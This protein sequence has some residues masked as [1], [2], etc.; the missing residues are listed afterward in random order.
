MKTWGGSLP[1]KK[2][3]PDGHIVRSSFAE[4]KAGGKLTH[5]CKVEF[6]ELNLVA[7]DLSGGPGP[8]WPADVSPV[9]GVILCYD[10]TRSETLIGLSEALARLC[11]GMP[12]VLLACKSDPDKTLEVEAHVGDQI[13]HPY[14]VGLIEVTT[15]TSQGKGKMRTGLR[16]LLYKLEEMNRRRESPEGAN[17]PWQKGH[18]V[19]Q[20]KG[21]ASDDQHSSS[22]SLG[23]MMEG[24]TATSTEGSLESEPTRAGGVLNPAEGVNGA[25]VA[26]AAAVA[27][28]PSAALAS[29]ASL[30][31]DGSKPEPDIYVTLQELFNRLFTAIVSTEN[32]QFVNTFFL[33]YRRFCQPRELMTE[34]LERFIE[35]EQYAVSRDIRLWAL[36]KLAGALKDWATKYPGDLVDAETQALF[37]KT[38]GCMLKYTFLAHVTV[39]LVSIE[40]GLDKVVDLDQSWSC[41]PNLNEANI[42]TPETAAALELVVE[43]DG[44]LFEDEVAPF[45]PTDSTTALKEKSGS[46]FSRSTASL[47][48]DLDPIP[49][50]AGDS[51][52]EQSRSVYSNDESGHRKWSSAINALMHMEPHH[53]ALELTLMQW[54][55]FAAIRPRD[56][57]RHDFGKERDDPVGRSIDFFNHLSR[58]VSTMILAH[59]KPKG[60]AKVY[61]VFVKIAH[62][63]RKLNNYDCLCAV[64]S[65][66]RETSIHRLGQTHQLV[67]LEPHLMRDYQSHLKLMDARNGYGHYRRALQADTSYNHTAIP[68]LSS[69]LGLVSRLQA[70]RPEDRRADGAVQWDKFQRFGDILMAIPTF[71]ERG[72]MVP[73]N[74][75]ISFR[76]LIEA[77]PV[78]SSEDGLYERSRLVEP[79][80]SQT[81]GVLRKLANF[82]L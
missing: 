51:S 5:D 28:I 38:L 13:G 73:G 65:G 3:T 36:M 20:S 4:I 27:A 80:G 35:V 19:S 58:W 37:R 32:D 74:V 22:S 44:I 63:L 66:L 56:V 10:A 18:H 8:I 40:Q 68:L 48:V 2:F 33:V 77:T 34:L 62:Q 75:S 57:F 67:R 53:F 16:W 26:A 17:A 25:A 1:V 82:S 49:P 76:R 11:P 59:P 21:S 30:D 24:E 15:A 72:G 52:S 6:V 41:R 12:A 69:I 61:E 46:T 45:P 39:D 71:Q 70:A 78:I 7:L 43:K 29:Q 47:T 81:G 23:W 79:G 60:R 42:Q 50:R 64:L 14:N 31:R 9:S 54:E 55:L